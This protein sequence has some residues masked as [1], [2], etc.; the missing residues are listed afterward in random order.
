MINRD[1]ITVGGAEVKKNVRQS[2]SLRNYMVYIQSSAY[3]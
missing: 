1:N 3:T 2:P